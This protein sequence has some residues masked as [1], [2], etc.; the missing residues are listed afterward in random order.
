VEAEQWHPQQKLKRLKSGEIELEVPYHD[1]RELIGDVLRF[2]KD[3]EVV[4]PADLRETVAA[5]VRAM[6]GL[7][8]MRRGTQ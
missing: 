3:C 5:E 4:A 1:P 8:R 7:Y 6:A 2:G